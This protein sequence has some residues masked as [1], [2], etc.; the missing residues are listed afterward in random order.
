M[1]TGEL[2]RL[3][4]G[5]RARK[6]G[7]GWI[8]R[9]PAHDDGTPSLSLARGE[10][11]VLVHCFGGYTSADVIEALRRRG[12]WPEREP[13]TRRVRKP[14]A[15]DRGTR[16]LGLRLWVETRPLHDG[17]WPA[18]LLNYFRSR[19][20]APFEPRMALRFHPRLPH[21]RNLALPALLALATDAD[22]QPAAVQ[23]TWLRADGSGK[24][25]GKR[26]ARAENLRPR[27]G[28]TSVLITPVWRRPR[29]ATQSS[30]VCGHAR[31]P[32]CE[33]DEP[34]E[35]ETGPGAHGAS[36]HSLSLGTMP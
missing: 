12:L 3:I 22:G 20:L 17:N 35:Q 25:H 32:A 16:D 26:A 6:S 29:P 23:A 30:I 11:R 24:A 9:C 2:G 13:R 5:L 1:R 28:Q 10:G 7:G 21:G 36:S 8:A 15:D 19:G 18:I 34:G 33:R 14:A 4:E 27:P 31:A